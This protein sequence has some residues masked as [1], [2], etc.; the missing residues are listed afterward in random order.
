M[1]S[2]YLVPLSVQLG[3]ARYKSTTPV[4]PGETQPTLDVTSVT[5]NGVT[6][7]FWDRTDIATRQAKTAK[8]GFTEEGYPFAIEDATTFFSETPDSDLVAANFTGSK[9]DLAGVITSATYN[10]NF[11]RNGLMKNPI[12]LGTLGAQAFD[13]R[14]AY[15]RTNGGPNTA[16]LIPHDPS[17]NV[18]SG[19]TGVNTPL[20]TGSYVKAVAGTYWDGAT[21]GPWYMFDKWSVLNVLPAAPPAGAFGPGIS[22]TDKTCRYKIGNWN[23]ACL[24]GF[25]PTTGLPNL[26]TAVG[27]YFPDGVMPFFGTGGDKRR[28]LQVPGSWTTTNYAGNADG[29]SVFF[30]AFGAALLAAGPSC[31]DAPLKRAAAF[32]LQQIG[33]ANRGHLMGYGAGQHGGHVF[34]AH[35]CAFLWPNDAALATTALSILGSEKNQPHW[36]DLNYY[37]K[38]VLWSFSNHSLQHMPAPYE[39]AVNNFADWAPNTPNPPAFNSDYDFQPVADYR[40]QATPGTS[41][42]ISIMSRLINGPGGQTGA[43][44][45]LQASSINPAN[46]RA[47]PLAYLDRVIQWPLNAF[48]VSITELWGR[49]FYAQ[50]RDNFGVARWQ[51]VPDALVPDN[52]R[53][54]NFV[55]PQANGFDYD[56]STLICANNSPLTGQYVEVSLDKTIWH[57]IPAAPLASTSFRSAPAEVPLYIRYKGINALGEGYWSYNHASKY[58]GTANDIAERMRITTLGTASGT[59]TNL[60]ATQLCEPEQANWKGSPLKPIVGS[61]NLGAN[62]TVYQPKGWWSGD[63]K[64]GAWSYAIESNATGSWVQVSSGATYD[65]QPADLGFQ[66]RGTTTYTLAATPYSVSSPPIN[67]PA[68]PPL[69][70]GVI[71]NSPLD[72]S[73]TLFFPTVYNSAKSNLDTPA[74]NSLNGNLQITTVSVPTT[75]EEGDV[76]V[77]EY[78]VLR[79]QKVASTGNPVLRIVFSNLTP[80]TSY[81]LTA[82][83]PLGYSSAGTEALTTGRTAFAILGPTVGTNTFGATPN[84]NTS[85]GSQ[86]IPID[87]TFTP[88]GNTA[89]LELRTGSNTS[90][91]AGGSPQVANLYLREA[92]IP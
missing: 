84:Y 10:Q 51:G 37:N 55:T 63:M 54:S 65:V 75:N 73:V 53:L 26:A 79:L 81:R 76:L 42:G 32:G 19:Y 91:T 14:L 25:T 1:F 23:K 7:S 74:G 86:L 41:F 9:I 80:G 57:R 78:N 40:G 44:F 2:R 47:A 71:F 50:E 72:K 90:S 12:I 43:Q 48:L 92:A 89:Y 18:S 15:V 3:F 29:Y 35:L 70:A 85:L 88:S 59:P 66:L 87:F 83:F 21:T 39:A 33:L 45:M 64:N 13:E 56:I 28:R 20:T 68:L 62:I 22:D 4:A 61:I 24:P 34:F 16:A 58:A 60:I 67:V 11:R 5:Y 69:P 49:A 36:L 27:T 30:N 52:G 31:P 38:A 8:V 17:L 6:Y 77:T 82:L 46:R